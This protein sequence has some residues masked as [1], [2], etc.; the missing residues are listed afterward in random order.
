MKKRVFSLITA[1]AVMTTMLVAFSV[2]V[3]AAGT[4]CRE[5]FSDT[6]YEN[7]SV[8]SSSTVTHSI[9]NGVLE[10][11]AIASG[12]E[13]RAEMY[14]GFDGKKDVI[15]EFDINITV[16]SGTNLST[17]TYFTIGSKCAVFASGTR[18]PAG[19]W[20]HYKVKCTSDGTDI[21]AA[22]F[23]YTKHGTSTS[24]TGSL[25][26]QNKQSYDLRMILRAANCS[27]KL[28]NFIIY[29][30]SAF[31]DGN[32]KIGTTTIT[33]AAQV[34]AGD[35]VATANIAAA[36]A[37][38]SLEKFMVAFDKNG[39]ML[40]V[41]NAQQT[42]VADTTTPVT[43]TM[44]LDATKAAAIADSGY[45]GLYLWD[46]MYPEVKALELK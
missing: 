16:S 10:F 14:D 23:E 30:E 36:V 44:T 18:F 38:P 8:N 37:K 1:I 42:L 25:L 27:V 34:T 17:S 46:G 28:D 35:L 41:I 9:S 6:T 3:S 20:Y 45:V 29:N 22:T 4:V 7:F 21:T 40:D 5:D 15:I 33:T 19:D 11:E 2:N 32:F 13:L 39:K 43:A 12:E 26:I 24:S 31:I